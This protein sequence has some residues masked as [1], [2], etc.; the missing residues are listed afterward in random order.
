MDLLLGINS[1]ILDK[2]ST[3]VLKGS[4]TF[5]RSRLMKNWSPL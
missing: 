3:E 5:Y 1:K 4:E 2:I